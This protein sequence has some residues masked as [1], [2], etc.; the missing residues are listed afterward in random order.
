M[1][2]KILLLDVSHFNDKLASRIKKIVDKENRYKLVSFSQPVAEKI[3]EILP[4]NAEIIWTQNILTQEDFAKIDETA[5]QII[6]NWHQQKDWTHKLVYQGVNL[7]ITVEHELALFLPQLLKKIKIVKNLL[8]KEK[9]EEII[10]ISESGLLSKIVQNSQK[11]LK[12]PLS[13]ENIILK[14][15]Q[16][17]RPYSQ[18]ETKIK[19]IRNFLLAKLINWLTW[20]RLVVCKKNLS[21]TKPVIL[22]RS[23][24]KLANILPSKDYQIVLMDERASR[25]GWSFMN[26]KRLPCYILGQRFIRPNCLSRKFFKKEIISLGKVLKNNYQFKKI[27]SFESVN[28]WPLVEDKFENIFKKVFPIQIDFIK[29]VDKLLQKTKPALVISSPG[30]TSVE[31]VI[32]ELAK[33]YNI[34]TLDVQHGLMGDKKGR[35]IIYACYVAVWGKETKKKLIEW[36]NSPNSIFVTGNYNF[37]N[38]PD[39]FNFISRKAL[40]RQL[41]IDPTQDI[42]IWATG[43]YFAHD[44]PYVSS[45]RTR[46]E[47]EIIFRALLKLLQK[48][49]DKQLVVKVHPMEDENGYQNILADFPHLKN[50]VKII[51]KV[52]LYSLLKESKLLLTRGSTVDLETMLFK[53][54]IIAMNFIKNSDF[55]YKPSLSKQA[56]LV[57]NKKEKLVGAVQDILSNRSLRKEMDKKQTDFIQNFAGPMDGCSGQRLSHVIKEIVQ[58]NQNN[59]E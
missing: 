16:I 57:V 46:D 31:R 18:K 12:Y 41:K 23:P 33:K 1:A 39:R 17:K 14:D 24:K 10:I 59:H 37:D 42:F 20:S 40:C 36:G 26:Q 21:G 4:F 8:L 35:E 2:K 47:G 50:R 38:F 3:K 58:T 25:Q 55:F 53:K 19:L 7:G 48:F 51:K 6:R 45:T 22:L 15:P 29:A 52:P 5:Y 34:P 13:V 27:F 9:P 54:P 30:V 32:F 11:L 49:T 44:L 28:F 43:V 56:I